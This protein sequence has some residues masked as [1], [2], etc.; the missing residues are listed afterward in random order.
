[1]T[2]K[3][4]ILRWPDLGLLR[5]GIAPPEPGGPGRRLQ[6]P[7]RSRRMGLL[8][9]QH[10]VLPRALVLQGLVPAA[11]HESQ[12]TQTGELLLLNRRCMS[13]YRAA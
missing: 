1:M 11:T 10:L 7:P 2:D 12:H 3:N 13:P 4:T 6:Q 9:L 5:E 8:V